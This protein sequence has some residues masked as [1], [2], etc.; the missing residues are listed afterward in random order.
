MVS[1]TAPPSRNATYTLNPA[2]AAK[3]RR[4]KPCRLSRRPTRPTGEAGVGLASGA[5][6][7]I[8]CLQLRTPAL[9]SRL[10]NWPRLGYLSVILIGE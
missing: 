2:L 3:H 1:A 10:E 4:R 5:S 8:G 9:P 7:L 6:A